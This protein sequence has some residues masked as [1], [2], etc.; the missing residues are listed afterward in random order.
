MV[1]LI[2]ARTKVCTDKGSNWKKYMLELKIYKRTTESLDFY[3]IQTFVRPNLCPFLSVSLECDHLLF[4]SSGH[5]NWSMTYRSD[6]DVP[7]PYGRVVRSISTGVVTSASSHKRNFHGEK[8]RGLAMLASNCGGQSG[9]YHYL[10][11]L[12]KN[13]PVTKCCK[14]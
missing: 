6:S 1:I 12:M 14:S 9:R 5:F 3:P 11:S 10:D 7:V 2:E 8:E 13:I 4:I